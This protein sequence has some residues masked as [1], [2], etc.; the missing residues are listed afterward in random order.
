MPLTQ[1]LMSLG[2]NQNS[3]STLLVER[4]FFLSPLYIGV[5]VPCLLL[6]T[7]ELH[8]VFVMACNAQHRLAELGGNL[9]MYQLETKHSVSNTNVI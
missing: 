7:L 5:G 6:P 3:Y 9:A 2:Q 4:N 8:I 1:R